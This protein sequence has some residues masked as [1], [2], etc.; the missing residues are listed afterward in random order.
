MTEDI[1]ARARHRLDL[2]V[3]WKGADDTDAKIISDLLV[4]V[5]R[6]EAR[7]TAAEADAARLVG[8]SSRPIQ[9]E[10]VM[11]PADELERLAAT[12]TPGKWRKYG[13]MTGKVISQGPEVGTVEICE[14]GDFRDAELIPYNSA[15]WN[16]D[17]D[18][19]ALVPDLL[20]E[21]IATRRASG[22]TATNKNYDDPVSSCQAN[23]ESAEPVAEIARLTSER[24]NERIE[25][26][27]T[28]ELLDQAL[29]RA[30][31]AQERIEVLEEALRGWGTAFEAADGYAVA[32]HDVDGKCYSVRAR[33]YQRLH[34]LYRAALD[35]AGKGEG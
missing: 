1:I 34:S 29:A 7:P 16:A 10:I 19:I 8:N 32:I 15:R 33:D 27:D 25:H 11:T 5:E 28:L 23:R 24:N 21:V 20:A 12:I 17:A 31:A 9:G 6:M 22:A 4:E 13:K 18:A 2:I 14:T 30:A 26:T 3:N 35:A